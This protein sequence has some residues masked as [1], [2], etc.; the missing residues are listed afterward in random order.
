MFIYIVQNFMLTLRKGL[1]FL[2]MIKYIFVVSW[3]PQNF[4]NIS[5][6]CVISYD[7]QVYTSPDRN[8]VLKA[9]MRNITG[10]M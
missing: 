5:Y 1:C 7:L 8:S 9:I 3:T 4:L 10:C 6:F 2:Y